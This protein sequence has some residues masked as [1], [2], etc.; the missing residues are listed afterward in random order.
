[1][2]RFTPEITVA[3]ADFMKWV[4][5]QEGAREINHDR[6]WTSCAVGEYAQAC[7][8]WDSSGL[9]WPSAY[10]SWGEYCAEHLPGDLYD[11]LGVEPG[12]GQ[13][14]DYDDLAQIIRE[15]YIESE[16]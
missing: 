8:D 14:V 5:Q 4:L 13:I 12:V 9:P 3:Q 16:S 11:A 10:V 2:I 15:Q 1:M 7:G 6:G